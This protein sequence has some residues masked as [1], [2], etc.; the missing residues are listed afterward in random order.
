[1][2]VDSPISFG[3]YKGHSISSL[4]SKYLW[5]VMENV[6]YREELIK[7]VSEELDFRD[8]FDKHHEDEP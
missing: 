8:R 7:A 2:D 1:M 6:E 5:W 4:P 3:K